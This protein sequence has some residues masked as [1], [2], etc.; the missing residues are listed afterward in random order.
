MKKLNQLT[1]RIAD[2]AESYRTDLE[3]QHIL[4]SGAE[5]SG[6]TFM[7]EKLAEEFTARGFL[8]VKYLYPHSNIVGTES[9]IKD[10]DH[11][12]GKK[13]VVLIDDF[14][15]LLLSMTKGE[16]KKLIA[17]FSNMHSPFLVATSTGLSEDFPK[18]YP[19]FDQ[20]FNSFQI[21]CF[22]KED[23]EDLLGEDIYNKV[24]GDSEFQ[25]KVMKLGGNLNYIKSFASLIH[26]NY[27][28]EDCLDI[29]IDEN[30]RY[31]RYMFSTLLVYSS[32]HYMVWLVLVRSLLQPM[33]SGK[34]AFLLLIHPQHCIDLKSEESS[35][36]QAARSEVLN[37]RSRIICLVNGLLDKIKG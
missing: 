1:W 15:K 18:R 21:P 27:G 31:F 17:I 22:E 34:V 7:I 25:E 9:L 24:K 14:D 26:P 5:G 35:R 32:A 6:K 19:L 11:L 13:A 30:E 8:M 37:I 33:F 10:L 23:L 29:V 20:F 28:T 12:L 16:H 3:P 4:I 2:L 36:K